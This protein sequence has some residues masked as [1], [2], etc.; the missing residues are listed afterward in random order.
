MPEWTPQIRTE[1]FILADGAQEANGKL[2][3]LGGGWDTLLSHTYPFTHPQLSLAV[4]LSV[5]W[6]E[7]ARPHEVLVDLVDEDGLS[8]LPEPPRLQLTLT[9]P[10][11]AGPGDEIALPFTLTLAQLTI[12]RPARYSVLLHVDGRV[13]ARTAFRASRPVLQE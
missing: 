8:I 9:R 7:S 6:S 1:C 3:I 2:Y 13:V 12:P 4:K 11:N 5:P 10:L